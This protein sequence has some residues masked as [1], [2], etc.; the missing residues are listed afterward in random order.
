M[1]S[2]N[3]RFTSVIGFSYGG[4]KIYFCG[5]VLL[6]LFLSVELWIIYFSFLHM[7]YSNLNAFVIINYR[8]LGFSTLFIYELSLSYIRNLEP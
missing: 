8:F 3:V 6:K 4:G 5:P 2:V 7:K 1:C